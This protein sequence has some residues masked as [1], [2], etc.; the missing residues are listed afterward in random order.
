MKKIFF[1]TSNKG[2][3]LEAEK[4]LSPLGFDV[5]QF[6]IYYPEIQASKL[7][8]VAHFGIEWIFKESKEKTVIIEDAG[9]FIHVLSNFPGVYSKYVFKTVGLSGILSLMEG[10]EDRSAHFE[11]C[12]GYYDKESGILLFKGDVDGIISPEAKGQHGFGY[13]PI[14]IPEG[15]QKTF[16]EMKIE[17]KNKY[18]HRA[19]AL[20][21]LAE[22]LSKR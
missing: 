22:F 6:K 9:L 1:A 4:F 5:E 20:L 10:R 17:E 3:L 8:E 18:S 14:F 7:E 13:D 15:E 2:K 19:R 11:S 12:I 21:K 16:A